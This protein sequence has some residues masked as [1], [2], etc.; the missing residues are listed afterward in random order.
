MDNAETLTIIRPYFGKL[1]ERLCLHPI[2]GKL[3]CKGLFTPYLMEKLQSLKDIR[4]DQNRAFLLY[5]RTQP[6]Q[7]LK[8]F[9]QVLQE[10]V[11]NASHQELAAEILDAIP[12]DPMEVISGATDITPVCKEILPACQPMEWYPMEVIGGV[13][14]VTVVRQEILRV[15]QSLDKSFQ[16][17]SRWTYN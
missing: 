3:F 1:E 5:L 11:G 4:M 9:C 6:I 12:P 14:E 13:I 8:T 15:Y 2:L 16:L 10:D 17:A 7:Q